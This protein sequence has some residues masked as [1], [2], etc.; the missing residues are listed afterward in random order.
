MKNFPKN[1]FVYFCRMCSWQ[2]EDSMLMKKQ[3]GQDQIETFV[4]HPRLRVLLVTY[5]KIK[6]IRQELTYV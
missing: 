3:E 1:L 5:A 6:Y 4:L 2:K